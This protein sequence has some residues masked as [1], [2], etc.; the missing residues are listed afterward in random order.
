MSSY[1]PTF[2]VN[3]H[4]RLPHLAGR[5]ERLQALA[6]TMLYAVHDAK[7]ALSVIEMTLVAIQRQNAA[8]RPHAPQALDVMRA[9]LMRASALLDE[10]LQFGTERSPQRERI[11]LREVI[12]RVVQMIR[13]A[14]AGRAPGS[15]PVEVDAHYEGDEPVFWGNERLLE[16]SLINLAFN[17]LQAL[18][19][20]G[21]RIDFFVATIP[22]RV[23]IRIK[24]T[25]PG[26]PDMSGADAP[27][28]GT[29]LGLHIAR[30]GI[31]AHGG[32]VCH[33]N[34][35]GA[36]AEAI[37]VLPIG[38]GRQGDLPRESLDAPEA[39]G[40]RTFPHVPR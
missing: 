9:A 36:G 38:D 31:E 8:G 2:M 15:G 39:S 1:S 21:G 23:E 3:Y 18:R 12:E 33:R 6:E 24:D 22:G 30:V 25:G 28:S 11:A 16:A 20:E 19:M 4:S 27:P 10:V 5:T 40:L 17:G 7:T 26:M 32:R 29:G 13:V 35:S 34:A 14:A 37:I